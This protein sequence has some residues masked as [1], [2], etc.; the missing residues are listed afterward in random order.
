MFFGILVLLTALALSAVAGFYSIVGLV[1]VFPGAVIPIILMGTV[2]EIAKLVLASAIYRHW[3]L[4]PRLIKGYFLVAIFILSL[5]TSMGI[6]G[7]LSKSHLESTGNTIQIETQVKDLDSQLSSKNSVKTQLDK[8]LS[9]LDLSIT[10]FY[11]KG[12]VNKGY[13]VQSNQTKQ[14]KQIKEQQ[15]IIDKEIL[16]LTLQKNKLEQQ[17]QNEEVKVGPIRYVADMIFGASDK[18][19]LERS[20][21]YLILIIVSVFDPLAILLVVAGN[22]ILTQNAPKENL[23]LEDIVVTDGKQWSKTKAVKKKK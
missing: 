1:A 22:M 8:T 11:N 20:V 12:L 5:I 17:I 6:F 14:R 21:R 13:R 16:D 18:G 10:S 7:F 15:A 9:D 3:T 19:S 2:L 4:F 23:E